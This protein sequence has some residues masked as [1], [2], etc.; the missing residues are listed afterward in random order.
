MRSFSNLPVS[1]HW[2]FL[3]FHTTRFLA[4]PAV[5]V[6]FATGAVAFSLSF[7]CFS[8]TVAPPLTMDAA[9]ATLAPVLFADTVHSIRGNG[10]LVFARR[11]VQYGA[12]FD[13]AWNGDSSFAAQLYGPL[14]MPL[15]SVR[16]VTSMR[17]LV[18]LGD[19]Q[20][21]Q[22]P[23]QRINFG[24]AFG[25][26]PVSWSDLLSALTLRYPCRAD[27]RDRP[28][29]LFTDKNTTRVVW[30]A[31]GC[32]GHAADI[33]AAVDNKTDRL[34]EIT[35]SFREFEQLNFVFANFR[36]GYAQEIRVNAPDNNYFF[37]TY[38][39]LTVSPRKALS[40]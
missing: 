26:F 19:S 39:A 27:L 10:N 4:G 34:S 28:D 9:T 21:M 12:A 30:R 37:I 14:G 23:S 36:G 7:L 25:E 1:F 17:W 35:Y 3:P 11:G 22:H 24:P 18:S 40:P 6:R 32:L 38:R 31:R 2:K 8:C 15:A 16:S 5:R 13:I 20:Y 29:S 33:S